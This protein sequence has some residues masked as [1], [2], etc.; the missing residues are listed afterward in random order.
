MKRRRRT[1]QHCLDGGIIKQLLRGGISSR[2]R[3]VPTCFLPSRCIRLSHR[4]QFDVRQARQQREVYQLCETATAN[5]SYAKFRHEEFLS[6]NC[7]ETRGAG[8]PQVRRFKPLPPPQ[9]RS[10]SAAAG[11]C[12][13]TAAVEFGSNLYHCLT[14]QVFQ[15]VI[16]GE[17]F[18]NAPFS[19]ENSDAGDSVYRLDKI[20]KSAQR[21][22]ACDSG[23][24]GYQIVRQS[25]RPPTLTLTLRAARK[26]SPGSREHYPLPPGS[27]LRIPTFVIHSFL[28][29][30]GCDLS[31]G[32]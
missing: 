18:G 1:D 17:R 2:T 11:G 32:R 8:P 3:S 20:K 25:N 19:L 4:G 26:P 12:G 27:S 9:C 6:R 30:A 23:R 28:Q 31:S 21:H 16:P 13:L 29:E 22:Q 24:T 14:V 7:P 10:L 5:E 15:E